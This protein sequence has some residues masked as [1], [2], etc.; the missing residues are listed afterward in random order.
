MKFI[1]LSMHK[2]A[3]AAVAVFILS[4]TT[5]YFFHIKK[6]EYQKIT[7]RADMTIKNTH[8]TFNGIMDFK[9][10]Q[11]KGIANIAGSV[12]NESGNEYIVQRTIFFTLTSYGG[13]PIW[14]SNKI[15]V[16]D[17]ENSPAALLSGTLPDF[18]VKPSTVNDVNIIPVSKDGWLITKSSI[19]LLYCKNYK[20]NN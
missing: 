1:K 13:T 7:C 5:L 14:L 20:V 16:S 3:I 17:V 2:M 19:P 8:S 15:V 10:G 18:Y 11:E 9:I 6:E 4:S 12:S